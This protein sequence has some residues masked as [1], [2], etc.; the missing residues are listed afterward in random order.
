MC[1]SGKGNY[2]VLHPNSLAWDLNQDPKHR[3]KKSGATLSTVTTGCSHLWLKDQKRYVKGIE[4]LALHSIP[5][6]LEIANAMSC[7]PVVLDAVSNTAQCFLA[8]N[9]MH[10]SSVG[11]VAALGLD[12]C[13]QKPVGLPRSTSWRWQ[14]T[15]TGKVCLSSLLCGVCVAAQDSLIDLVSLASTTL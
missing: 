15:T 10:A 14:D 3:P 13:V 1:C 12:C 8:G 9:S 4:L 5:V 11:T 6:T 7:A 2:D